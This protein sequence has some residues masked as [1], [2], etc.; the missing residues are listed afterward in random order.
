VGPLADDMRETLDRHRLFHPV[1][2]S[3][4]PEGF[5]QTTR[6]AYILE[7]GLPIYPVYYRRIFDEPQ[8][9]E[10]RTDAS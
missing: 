6:E 8:T 10:C 4:Y 1:C 5:E 7:A 3:E 9:S 2:P